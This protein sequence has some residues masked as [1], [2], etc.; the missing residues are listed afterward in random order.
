MQISNSNGSNGNRSND[1]RDRHAGKPGFSRRS[2]LSGLTLGLGTAA[3]APRL[4]LRRALAGGAPDPTFLVV[5]NLF[6][7]NDSLNMFV[8]HGFSAYYAQRPAIA[9]PAGQLL[10]ISATEGLHPGLAPIHP[11]FAGGDLAVIRQVGY[12]DPNLSHFESADI[13]SKGVRDLSPGNDNRGWIGRAADLYFPGALDVVGVAVG[14]RPDFVANTAKPLVVDTLGSYGPGQSAVPWFEL[15]QRDAAA[16]AMLAASTAP[17]ASPSKDLRKSLRNAYDLVDVIKAAET[18][19]ASTVTYPDEWFSTNLRD[20]AQLVQ[21]GL[22]GR[23][24]YVGM[25]GF[26][27]HSDQL[28]GH[29]DLMGTLARGLDAFQKDLA[30][31]GKW[32]KAAIVVA[33][34][35][36]RRVYDN[37]SEGTDHGHGQ[38]V[39]VMGGAMN[40][41]VYGP[42]YTNA[43]LTDNEDVPGT[44]DFR[45]IY[46]NVLEKHLGVSAGAGV[47]PEAWPGDQRIPLFS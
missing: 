6:G 43:I 3:L 46:A 32:N 2:L 25:G 30:A 40:G 13:W 17:E 14:R 28:P 47:F 24:F 15:E 38:N 22:G 1:P 21:A 26:D 33:S 7:G 37:S 34:E 29:A 41:G 39:F 27:T 36:G 45:S 20:V 42:A 9:L 12:P 44:V 23:V 5:V 18:S 8:P 16:K 19:Y 31:M 11:L 35:F 4:S 10:P